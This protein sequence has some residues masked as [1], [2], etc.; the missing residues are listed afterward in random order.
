MT[1]HRRGNPDGLVDMV[2]NEGRVQDQLVKLDARIGLNLV[3]GGHY[4]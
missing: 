2:R 4:W 1:K 3:T